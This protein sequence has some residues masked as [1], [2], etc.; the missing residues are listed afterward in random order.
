MLKI[1]GIR[2]ALETNNV[3]RELSKFGVLT[4]KLDRGVVLKSWGTVFIT[5]MGFLVGVVLAGVGGLSA[6]TNV[7][8][9][10]GTVKTDVSAPKKIEKYWS[11]SGLGKKELFELISNANCRSSEKYFLACI[12]S[13][14][15][16]LATE[17]KHL[18]KETGEVEVAIN[19][20]TKG[21]DT[22]E[23][24]RLSEYVSLYLEQNKKINFEKIWNELL[25]RQP[26]NSKAN[27]IASGINAFLS[28]YK[29]PHTYIL[30]ENYYEE[31]G[32]QIERSNIFVGVS[33]EKNK[34][35]TI[36]RK[37]FKNS[38]AE[39]SGLQAF[40]EVLSI[41]DES[42]EPLNL[43][44]ISQI[45]KK[46]ETKRFEF[47]V[48]RNG[49]RMKIEVVRSYK[50]LSH[51]Q[52]EVLNGMK[53][54][55]VITLTKFSRGVCEEIANRIK[56]SA[57]KNIAGIVL[58]LR[59]N[60][61]GQLDEAACVAGLFLGMNKKTYSVEFFD[62]LKTNEV[63][64]STGSLLYTGPLVI[65]INSASASASELLSGAMKDYR[66]A[67]LVGEKTFGKGTFQESE[68]WSKNEKV[69]LFKTQGFYLLPSRRSTQL[70]GVVPD[71]EIDEQHLK[72]REETMFFNPLP[73]WNEAISSD[74]IVKKN[75]EESLQKC[76]DY[77]E[78]VSQKDPVMQKSLQV[79]SC[80]RLTSL[81]AQQYSPTDFN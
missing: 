43:I 70:V 57:D 61:G 51:V 15:E 54:F 37:V 33:F 71:I 47:Q 16:N 55:G 64:L 20:F 75:Y 45:L 38:D 50:N 60:P 49:E 58:D 59:D 69:T 7:F 46:S 40:D 62:P 12:N 3:T 56:E 2:V 1:S 36:V 39:I 48:V 28:V 27:L 34:A 23:K 11:E 5:A 8:S 66:R 81:L 24:Q 32:S 35:K 14:V 30:P 13:V 68:V 78:V 80:S 67:I 53:N 72:L 77:S 21:E 73:N 26:E 22:T 6:K 79:L 25:E 74:E 4:H 41:N 9:L 44:E 10:S 31:V 29:D 17:H 63:V 19:H 76:L 18:S 42:L 52:F 65:A